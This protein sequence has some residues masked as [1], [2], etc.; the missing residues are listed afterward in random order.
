MIAWLR[1]CLEEICPV[2]VK[3]FAFLSPH[4]RCQEKSFIAQVAI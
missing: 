3:K 2:E 4:V 1:E